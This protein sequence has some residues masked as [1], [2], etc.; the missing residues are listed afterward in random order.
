MSDCVFEINCVLFLLLRPVGGL[1]VRLYDDVTTDRRAWFS[2]YRCSAADATVRRWTRRWVTQVRL[3][4]RRDRLA[5]TDLRQHAEH[6]L[7][8]RYPSRRRRRFANGACSWRHGHGGRWRRWGWCE[9]AVGRAV[10]ARVVWRH[11]RSDAAVLLRLV[12]VQDALERRV[13]VTVV[14]VP[15]SRMNAGWGWLSF[16]RWYYHR[17]VRRTLRGLGNDDWGGR[18]LSVEDWDHSG[19]ATWGTGR[20]DRFQLVLRRGGVAGGPKTGW[21]VEPSMQG[22]RLRRRRPRRPA[23]DAVIVN[24]HRFPRLTSHRQVQYV[25]LTHLTLLLTPQYHTTTYHRTL[26]NMPVWRTAE[27]CKC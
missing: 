16:R 19:G 2:R 12:L 10:G 27:D 6:E 20:R 17:C 15:T 13:R 23:C 7:F 4:R 26:H 24:V 18:P 3:R 14:T 1:A 11:R 25:Q 8:E 9:D 5:A 22:R 21:S